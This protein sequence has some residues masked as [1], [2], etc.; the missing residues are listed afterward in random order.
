MAVEVEEV[1]HRRIL[2]HPSIWYDKPYMLLRET[3][4]PPGTVL[5]GRAARRPELPCCAGDVG[6]F[7]QDVASTAYAFRSVEQLRYDFEQDVLPEAACQIGPRSAAGDAL[8]RFEAA[9]NRVE[10]GRGCGL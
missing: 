2:A 1:L 8:D 7:T 9:W 10:E 6:W 4:S 5:D 3:C